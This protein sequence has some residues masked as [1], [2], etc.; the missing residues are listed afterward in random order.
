MEPSNLDHEKLSVYTTY[1]APSDCSVPATQSAARHGGIAREA[2]FSQ[3]SGNVKMV[4]GG[5]FMKSVRNIPFPSWWN[6]SPTA[7]QLTEFEACGGKC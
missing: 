3:S 6:L 2:H 4:I 7:E 5:Q 1:V